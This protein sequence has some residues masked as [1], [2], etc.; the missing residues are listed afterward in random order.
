MSGTDG[1][2]KKKAAFCKGLS[3]GLTVS[4]ACVAAGAGRNTVYEWRKHDEAFAKAWEDALE[5]GTDVLEREAQR[6]ALESSD[7]LLIFLLKGRRPEKYRERLSV[8]TVDK[9]NADPRELTDAELDRRIASRIAG[10]EGRLGGPAGA[11]GRPH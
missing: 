4:D 1:T 10:L 7:T 5:S 6:R 9:T 3:D 2:A 11:K 8:E